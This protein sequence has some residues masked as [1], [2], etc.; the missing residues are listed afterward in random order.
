MLLQARLIA[1][2]TIERTNI[3]IAMQSCCRML[4]QMTVQH[5]YTC[6]VLKLPGRGLLCLVLCRPS[7]VTRDSSAQILTVGSEVQ[8]SPLAYVAVLCALHILVASS[9]QR[10]CRVQK[11]GISQHMQLFSA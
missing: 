1:A 2:L 4:F 9:M 11:Q 10:F 7:T 5:E 6:S 3:H 8:G